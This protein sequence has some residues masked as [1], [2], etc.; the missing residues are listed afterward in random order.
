MKSK[1]IF[2]NSYQIQKIISY[3]K[4]SYKINVRFFNGILIA[5]KGSYSQKAKKELQEYVDNIWKEYYLDSMHNL[6]INYDTNR[7]QYEIKSKRIREEFE[8]NFKYKKFTE[9]EI[10]EINQCLEE[11]WE[12]FL[13]THL[14]SLESTREAIQ[15]IELLYHDKYGCI[16]CAGIIL[17]FLSFIGYILIKSFIR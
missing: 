1:Y 12:V 16:C 7:E 5:K 11:D 9:K 14:L 15:F 17:M 2:S 6:L 13:D 3:I 8:Q 10:A 4:D